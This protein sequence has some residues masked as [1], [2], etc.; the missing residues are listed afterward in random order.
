[1]LQRRVLSIR[2]KFEVHILHRSYIFRV[3]LKFEAQ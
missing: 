1:L 2:T 3:H